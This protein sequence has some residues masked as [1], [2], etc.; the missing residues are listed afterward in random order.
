M[1]GNTQYRRTFHVIC[2]KL[3]LITLYITAMKSKLSNRAVNSIHY[4]PVIAFLLML[5]HVSL[6]IAGYEL[7]ISEVGIILLGF[8]I[9]YNFSK[10]LG[11]CLFHRILIYYTL[12]VMA[13]IWLRRYPEGNNGIFDEYIHVVRITLLSIG[14]VLFVI[15]ILRWLNGRKTGK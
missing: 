2:F 8:Y 7:P 10:L 5:F 14:L 3:L 12:V 6:L 4:V 1:C 15:L 11:F 9:T 13:C